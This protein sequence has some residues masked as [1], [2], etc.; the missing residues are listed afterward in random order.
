MNET[1]EDKGSAKDKEQKRFDRAVDLIRAQIDEGV[2]RA[3]EELEAEDV[4]ELL[5]AIEAALRDQMSSHFPDQKL[6][7][8]DDCGLT[9]SGALGALANEMEGSRAVLESK[10][11]PGRH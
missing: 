5:E 6:P 3:C 8:F 2:S 10:I 4:F 11:D 1:P 7:D 9:I